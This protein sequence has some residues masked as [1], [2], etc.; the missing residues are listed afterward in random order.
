MDRAQEVAPGAEVAE[1]EE[2]VAE[3]AEAQ[4]EVREKEYIFPNGVRITEKDYIIQCSQ[5]WNDQ[6]TSK[7][8]EEMSHLPYEE[9]MD[10]GH[11]M[12][13]NIEIWTGSEKSLIILRNIYSR[14]L[15]VKII[16]TILRV[17]RESG[18]IGMGY[19]LM[20]NILVHPNK[21]ENT[22][23]PKRMRLERFLNDVLLGRE[24][25]RVPYQVPY[26][27]MNL[28]EYTKRNLHEINGGGSCSGVIGVGCRSVYFPEIE[29]VTVSYPE[30]R[31]SSNVCGVEYR[32]IWTKFRNR[33]NNSRYR[34]L[35]LILRT[36]A[37]KVPR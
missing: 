3:V 20:I 32:R 5:S 30:Y 37:P 15:K 7:M 29:S 34:K 21:N 23:K 36:S 9:Y 1:G 11:G 18:G 6:E 13:R 16:E 24:K 2:G 35:T 33:S 10:P 17:L 8:L 26:E 14:G 28:T 25:D 4:Q 19:V 31:C 27:Q 22:Y 12:G